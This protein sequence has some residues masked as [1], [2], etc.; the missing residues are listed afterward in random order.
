MD[1]TVKRPSYV[2]TL[3]TDVGKY[4]KQMRFR[5]SHQHACRE[6]RRTTKRHR[7]IPEDTILTVHYFTDG[8]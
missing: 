6:T 2:T 4:Q 1:E 3:I 5:Q 7:K 8:K